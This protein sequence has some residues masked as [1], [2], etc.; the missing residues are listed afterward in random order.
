M[1]YDLT[2]ERKPTYLHVT[3]TGTRNEENARRFLFDAYRASLEHNCGSLLL[4]M[5]LSGASLSLASVYAVI[6]ERS[7]DGATLQRI[8]YVD[9][10]WDDSSEFAELA[11]IN[12]GVN[13]RLFRRL[14][15]AEHWL[16]TPLAPAVSRSANLPSA[17]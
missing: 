5:N 9:A 13:V 12:R 14:S 3:A 6:S 10:Q 15:D 4:E 7:P 16:S 11:A 1:S 2:I 17:P 8:A